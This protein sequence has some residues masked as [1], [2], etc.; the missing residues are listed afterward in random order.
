MAQM[1]QVLRELSIGVLTAGMSTRAV[2]REWNVHFQC[3]FREFV[4]TSNRPLNR[5]PHVC[6]CVGEQFADVN[7]V[8]NSV[9][10]VAVGL[11]HGQA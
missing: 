8:N 4:S 10:M 2:D 6:R 5:A 7:S 3:H 1:S 9:P 11:C